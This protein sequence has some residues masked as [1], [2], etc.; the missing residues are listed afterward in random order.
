MDI[1]T[2]LT[3]MR[4]ENLC[5]YFILPLCGLTK[6]SFGPGNFKESYLSRTGEYLYVAVYSV[7]LIPEGSVNFS[8]EYKTD[9]A[10]V[11]ILIPSFLQNDLCKFIDGK[12]ST[13]S[14]EAKELI[15]TKSGLTYK[16]EL[17]DRPG[18]FYTD[19]RLMALFKTD[20][21]I[22]ELRDQLFGER[23]VSPWDNDPTLELLEKPGDTM[24]FD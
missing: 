3:V 23:E 24:F 8:I 15:R 6:H 20:N 14:P 7:K 10:F 4:E 16:L 22:A 2:L 12:F 13:M 19:F 1:K 18:E 5:T 21:A 9:Q 17:P 11:R